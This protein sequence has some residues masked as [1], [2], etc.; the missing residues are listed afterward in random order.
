MP[1]PLSDECAQSLAILLSLFNQL[2]LPLALDNL[3]GPVPCLKFLG[4]E[5]DSESMVIRLL[6]ARVAKLQELTR[7][8]QKKKLSPKKELEL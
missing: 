5:L 7:M 4:L 6:Q 2:A 8:W 3:E 1:R